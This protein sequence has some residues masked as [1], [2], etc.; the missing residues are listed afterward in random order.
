MNTPLLNRSEIASASRL[1]VKV[2]SS[3]LTENTGHLSLPKLK[4]L[5]RV[6]AARW[7]QNTQVVLVSSGAQATGMGPLGLAHKPRDLATAQAAASVGQGLLIAHYSKEF[8]D[9]GF[10]VGQVLL[11]AED[12]LRRGHYR[13]A[14]RSLQKLLNLGVVPIVNENDT[15]ATDEIRFGDNDRLAALVAHL[16]HADALVLLTDVDGLYTAPPK[17]AGAQKIAEVNKFS[18]VENLDIRSRGSAV[19]T[20]GMTTKVQAAALATSSGIPVL[21]TSAEQAQQA[22]TD[23]KV[24]TWFK[25][26]GRR[27]PARQ[28]WL[29]YAAEIAGK[30]IVDAGAVKAVSA[31]NA[32]L[33][34]AGV[35]DV[36]GD[37]RA[38][39]AVEIVD[40]EGLPI[41]R[42]LAGFSAERTRQVMGMSIA[43]IEKQIG[44]KYAHEVVHRDELVVM[45]RHR[46]LDPLLAQR[47]TSDTAITGKNL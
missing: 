34:P 13:N 6:I 40:K 46:R 29:A 41:A 39:Q 32:S 43:E 38:G 28:L 5:V 47:S 26:T 1:V 33:L 42:G 21:L 7:G 37:F 19:G 30:I 20:G 12:I 44:D 3:S 45:A 8:S 11:T 35:I 25:A 9:Y 4:E 17:T 18:E 10:K 16:V 36:E 22:L 31:R 27:L 23:G 14:R 2:G 15:V 24:G